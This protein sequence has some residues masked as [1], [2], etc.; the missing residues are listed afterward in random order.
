MTANLL[1]YCGQF[2]SYSRKRLQLD[3]CMTNRYKK[4]GERK[5]IEDVRCKG[6]G[7]GKRKGERRGKRQI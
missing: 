6:K 5:K 7:R 3:T 4:E 1:S 2:G